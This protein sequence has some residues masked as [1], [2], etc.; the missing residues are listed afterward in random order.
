MQI[1]E[2][3]HTMHYNINGV[4]KAVIY[5]NIMLWNICTVMCRVVWQGH[6]RKGMLN[7]KYKFKD[8][9]LSRTVMIQGEIVESATA[10]LLANILMYLPRAM[11]AYSQCIIQRFAA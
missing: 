4:N 1:T 3:Q 8:L 6:L 7:T 9:M 5:T 11:Q 2:V 10:R